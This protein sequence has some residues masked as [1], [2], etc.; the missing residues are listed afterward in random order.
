M[1]LEQR[2]RKVEAKARSNLEIIEDIEEMFQASCT[3]VLSSN[4]LVYEPMVRA[5]TIS[6]RH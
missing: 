1:K 3:Q 5:T 4:K 6:Y 2:C